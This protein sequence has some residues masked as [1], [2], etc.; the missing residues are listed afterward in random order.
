MGFGGGEQKWGST[1]NSTR[2]MG[3][4]EQGA[5]WGPWMENH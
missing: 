4:Y 1:T 5:E 2:K 3:I